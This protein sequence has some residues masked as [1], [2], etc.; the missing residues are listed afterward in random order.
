M[1]VWNRLY[2]ALKVGLAASLVFFVAI[3]LG[4]LVGAAAFCSA[5]DAVTRLPGICSA[6]T[7]FTAAFDKTL[8][9][10]IL[11]FGLFFVSKL[12]AVKFPW[13]VK[14]IVKRKNI[15]KD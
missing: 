12:F 8:I 10:V 14:L 9:P 7:G 6:G 2:T 4:N 3:F 15:R 1:R 11:I 13:D 5:T